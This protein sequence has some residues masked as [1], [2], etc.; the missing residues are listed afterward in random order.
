MPYAPKV[1]LNCTSGSKRELDQL[2]EQFIADGV[3]F[4][5]VVGLECA[6]VEDMVDW[7]VIGDG[8]DSGRY[9]LTSSHP[10]ESLQDAIDFARALSDEYPGEPQVV[11]L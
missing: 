11:A 5:G 6:L 1:V 9:I 3:R 8:S 2:V 10:G 7:L 4:V